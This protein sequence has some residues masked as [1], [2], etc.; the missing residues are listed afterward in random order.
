[1]TGLIHLSALIG[2]TLIVVRSTIF[3]PVR[4]LWPAL[5][6]CAQCTGF[7]VGFIAGATGVV[8]AGH[9]R[10]VD[11]IVVGC[12]ASFLSLLGDAV[13]LKLLGDPGDP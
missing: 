4:K 6:G 8:Q 5:L 12:S 9:G 13:L 1:M 10:I 2:A 7:H 3:A 11:A